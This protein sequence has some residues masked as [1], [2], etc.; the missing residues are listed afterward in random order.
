M[1][2]GA[3]TDDGKPVIQLPVGGRDWPA[4]IDT[5]FNGDLELPDAL[6]GAVNPRYVTDVLSILAAGVEVLEEAYDV[7]FPFDGR[8][9]LAEAT[10]VDGSTILV[11][12]GMLRD[13][14]LEIDFVARTVKLDRVAAA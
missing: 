5:G 1:I 7:D 12:T 4:I 6:R 13:Y 11:G 3:V 9:T 8:T 14:R 10:F 2:A